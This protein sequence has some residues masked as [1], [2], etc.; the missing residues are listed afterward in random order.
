MKFEYL[1]ATEDARQELVLL[2]GWGTNREIWRPL[3]VAL[4]PWANI[5]LLDVPGCAPG[6][7]VGADLRQTLTAI[8][9]CCPPRAVYVGW[10]LGGQLAVELASCYP[11][12]V[13]GDVHR[14][15]AGSNKCD[16][17]RDRSLR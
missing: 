1:P 6:G 13:A 8:V 10:S 7:A 4:R 11:Q 5:T 2:H 16:R 15:D 17:C 14:K 3:L 12:Q 9:E